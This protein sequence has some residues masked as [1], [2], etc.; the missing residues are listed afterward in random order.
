MDLKI[1]LTN[2]SERWKYKMDEW[3]LN[4]GKDN[5]VTDISASLGYLKNQSL[6]DIV[7]LRLIIA[8]L[9]YTDMDTYLC[10]TLTGNQKF[11]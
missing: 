11:T 1:A 5:T 10:N 3:V 7:R 4:C 2:I 6:K 9:L 8:L